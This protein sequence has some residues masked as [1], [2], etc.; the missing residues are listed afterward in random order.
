MSATSV[1]RRYARALFSIGLEDGQFQAYAEQLA[2]VSG[3]FAGSAELQDAW[4][5]PAH[6][7]AARLAVAEQ[8]AQASGLAPATAN[9]LKL[10]VERGRTGELAAIARSYGEMVDEKNGRLRAVVTSATPLSSEQQGAL[11]RALCGF[12]GKDVVLE[13]KSDPA[14]IGG[15]TTQ[16]GSTVVDG[17][18]RTQLE[19]LRTALSA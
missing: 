9:L 3:A 2:R 12:T 17:S 19:R 14:L 4:L 6:P 8:L 13:A 16:I 7:G 5:N 15:L 11:Q 1:A 18:V 10:L